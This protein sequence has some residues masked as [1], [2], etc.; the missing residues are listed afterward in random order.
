MLN[1]QFFYSNCVSSLTLKVL[2]F[3]VNT[4]RCFVACSRLQDN[5]VVKSCSKRGCKKRTGAIFSR[6]RPLPQ[7]RLRASYFCLAEG[8]SNGDGYANITQKVN[9]RFFKLYRAYSI[10][11]NSSNVGEFFWSWSLKDSIEVEGEK[12]KVVVFWSHPPQNL[13]LETFS[14]E[15]GN[16]GKEMYKNAW[17]T[18]KVVVLLI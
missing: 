11:S 9:S 10:L 17:C 16:D 7:I 1:R 18:C 13:K 4:L 15:S 5:S 12:K 2:R 6:Y 14:S 3:L 8:L